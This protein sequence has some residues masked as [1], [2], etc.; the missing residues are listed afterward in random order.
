MLSTVNVWMLKHSLCSWPWLEIRGSLSLDIILVSS[1]KRIRQWPALR[2]FSLQSWCALCLRDGLSSPKSYCQSAGLFRIP[3]LHFTESSW[4]IIEADNL[5]TSITSF[6]AV[7]SLSLGSFLEKNTAMAQHHLY[8]YLEA[9]IAPFLL[10]L[11][12]SL[13]N[14]KAAVC[15]Y[16]AAQLWRGNNHGAA[17]CLS[18]STL[19]LLLYINISILGLLLMF[20][21]C[22]KGDIILC[23][24]PMSVS[25]PFSFLFLY[26]LHYWWDMIKMSATMPYQNVFYKKKAK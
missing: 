4:I 8:F 13:V 10:S 18:L 1:E 11:I 20:K 14:V 16:V 15:V 23:M 9:F 19:T 2:S 3:S 22:L 12:C 25:F 6:R 24:Y 21:K 5:H 26:R 17:N 7:C